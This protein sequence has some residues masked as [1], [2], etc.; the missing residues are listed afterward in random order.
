MGVEETIS[1]HVPQ[2]TF[3]DE[4][5]TL[6]EDALSTNAS[7]QRALEEEDWCGSRLRDSPTRGSR[8]L[9]LVVS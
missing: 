8:L 6:L 3:L 1:E 7:L 9:V 2:Q 4:A 5:Q